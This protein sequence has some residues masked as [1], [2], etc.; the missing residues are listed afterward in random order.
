MG[1]L[2]LV[3]LL[4]EFLTAQLYYLMYIWYCMAYYIASALLGE[5]EVKLLHS[6]CL[7]RSGEI[8]C[9]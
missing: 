1:W 8:Y 4:V 2:L 9:G 5:M 3:F 6:H 7:T